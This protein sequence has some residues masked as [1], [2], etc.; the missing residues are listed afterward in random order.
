M[1]IYRRTNATGLALATSANG[2]TRN[3]A[4]LSMELVH[5]M[6]LLVE[7]ISEITTVAVAATFT[8]QVSADN[9]T[10]FDLKAVNNV[11]N[12]ATPVGTGV[13]VTTRLALQIDVPHVYKFFR[14]NA[15]L[16]GAA[17]IAADKT[18]VTYRYIQPEGITI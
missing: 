6:T 15:V 8:P 12:V 11:A 2:T 9:T 4:A 1:A 14:C 10:Y 5:P 17:T 13:A 16:A 18:S 3:G 7:C